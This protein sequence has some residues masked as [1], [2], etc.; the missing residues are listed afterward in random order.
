MSPDG[1]VAYAT[2]LFA[3]ESFS[4]LPT[5]RV[6]SALAVVKAQNGQDGLTVGAN[7]IF[8]FVQGEPPSSESIG[9]GVA[10]FIL[11][12]AFGSILGA[13]LPIV[14]AAVSVSVTTALVLPIVADYFSVTRRCNIFCW[15]ASSST[16]PPTATQTHKFATN[17]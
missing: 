7:G 4:D 6:A 13:F 15:R 14:S 8:G 2:V 11:L 10:L 16:Y 5:E 17:R 12:F 9:V 1:T 3:G